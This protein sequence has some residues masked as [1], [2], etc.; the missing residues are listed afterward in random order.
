MKAKNLVAVTAAAVLLTIP[1]AIAQMPGMDMQKMMQMM[2][3]KADDAASTKDFK[4]AHM[5]MMQNM[6]MDFV[7]NPDVDFARSMVKHHES[8]IAMAKIE[9]KHGKNAEIRSMA[10]KMIK[11]QE[12][13]IAEF[14]AWLKKNA[15]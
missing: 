7:G 15:K 12:K 13:E 5:A 4:Q 8:G 10:E 11:D 3:P 9:L 14:N 1:V 6:N 2:N